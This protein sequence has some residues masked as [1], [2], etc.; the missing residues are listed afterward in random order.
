MFATLFFGLLDPVTGKLIYVN[1]GHEP[2]AIL[3]ATGVR[4]HLEPTA[5][6]VGLFPGVDYEI[7]EAHLEP[8]DLLFAFTDGV[9][10]AQNPQGSFYEEDGL[11]KSVAQHLGAP[12]WELVSAVLKDIERFGAEAQFGDDIALGILMRAHS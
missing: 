3:N 4:T 8:G 9:T 10:E 6:A 2:P 7:G 5:P 11:V 12:A 1:G